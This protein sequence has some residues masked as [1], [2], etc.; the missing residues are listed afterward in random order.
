MQLTSHAS[1]KCHQLLP[2]H[3]DQRVLFFLILNLEHSQISSINDKF[4]SSKSN[5]AAIYEYC[6]FFTIFIT[7]PLI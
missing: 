6:S 5:V 2:G 3:T 1:P 7:K 4:S